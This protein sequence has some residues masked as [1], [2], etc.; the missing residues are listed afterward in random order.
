M[1][2]APHTAYCAPARPRAQLWRLALGLVLIAVIYLGLNW[3]VFAQAQIFGG[4]AAFGALRAVASDTTRPGGAYFILF[5]FAF[6]LIAIGVATRLVHARSAA[7]LIGPP[8][9][10]LRQGLR[11]LAALA[12]LSVAVAVLPPRELPL[13]I[14][15]GLPP[16]LWLTLLPV[17]LLA[18]LI[19]TGAEEVAFRGYLQQQLGARFASPAVWIGVPTAL[20]ALLHYAP[21]QSGDNAVLVMAWSALFAV[22]AADLTARSGTLGPAI[23]LHFFNNAMAIL[24]T[25]LDGT[26]SGLALYVLPMEMTDTAALRPLMMID[27]GILLCSWLAARLAL[28]V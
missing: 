28:R 23:A 21:D 24:L 3:A 13:E 6:L 1:S 27:I 8:R 22:A 15:P 14:R 7:G 20:F 17:S 26:M 18:V 11:V 4:P 12:I 10:A 2:Y 9:L 19:Q 16:G 5:S 25:S